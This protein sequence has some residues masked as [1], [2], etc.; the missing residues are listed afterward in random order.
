MYTFIAILSAFIFIYS[1][2]S[3]ILDK[4]V[5]TGAM[6]FTVFGVLF[7]PD[8]LNILTFSV[9]NAEL[10]LLA[11]LTLALVLFTDA[12]NANL[13]ELKRSFAIPQRLIF[14][15]LPLTILL[16]FAVGVMIFDSLTFLEIGVLATMLAATDAA[17]G[18]SVIMNKAVPSRIRESLNFES[19]LNDGVCVPILF[20]FLTIST[21]QHLQQ[22][23]VSLALTLLAKEIGIGLAVR[24]G[25]SLL[26]SWLI[27]R[28]HR[29]GWITEVWKPQIIV[30]LAIACFTLAQSLHGSGFIATFVGGLLFGA[31][32]KEHKH[33]LMNSAEGAGE[34]L[35]LI[36]W[37]IFG[38]TVI[39]Q[40]I[41]HI[42]WPVLIYSILSLTVIRM[43]PVGLSLIGTRL[44]TSE[45]L[46]IGWFGP[47]GL[48]TIVFSIIVLNA[49][50]PGANTIAI[51]AA[52]TIVLSIF[53]HGI[54]A[55]PLISVL[56][57][58]LR[59]TGET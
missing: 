15:G 35:G 43:L 42:S 56:A 29:L 37:V 46:F 26:G 13:S 55:V 2:S 30:A 19:G 25:M 17:L 14:V 45:K 24:A 58:R 16:G 39:S 1:L 44:Q 34:T 36:T 12:A 22:S 54:S 41:A 48:A 3:R 4:T 31:L 40:S 27:V 28:C 50:L 33:E 7:G 5:L 52:C 59:R 23:T 20:L 9:D 53:A 21:A 32:A 10:Q 57:S 8:V 51:T 49:N 47:R 6:V 18:K 11:E 38:S